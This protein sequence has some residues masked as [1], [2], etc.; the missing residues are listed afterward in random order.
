MVEQALA[1]KRIVRLQRAAALTDLREHA[2]L[3]QSDVA[4][5]L[6]VSQSSVSRWEANLLRPTAQHAFDLLRLL[7]GEAS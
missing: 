7:D 4:R 2:G 3:S 5:A 6:D 1:R